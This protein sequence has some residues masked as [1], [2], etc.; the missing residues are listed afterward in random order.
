MGVKRGRALGAAE[1][2]LIVGALNRG[3]LP[4]TLKT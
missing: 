2:G 3:M 1:L 4:Q